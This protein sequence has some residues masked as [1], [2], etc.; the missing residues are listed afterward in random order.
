MFFVDDSVLRWGRTLKYTVFIPPVMPLESNKKN[1]KS[2]FLPEKNSFL[3][4][5]RNFGCFFVDNSVLRR[6]RIFK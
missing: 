4:A 5:K 3:L 6:D 2:N 1:R